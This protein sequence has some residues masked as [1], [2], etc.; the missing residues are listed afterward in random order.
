MELFDQWESILP[1]FPK[2]HLRGQ[3][4]YLEDCGTNADDRPFYYLHVGGGE[5]ELNQ[6]KQILIQI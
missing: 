2:W 5:A 1:Q 4:P 6:Y 3:D